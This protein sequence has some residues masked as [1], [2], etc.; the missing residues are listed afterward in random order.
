M[1]AVIVSIISRVCLCVVTGEDDTGNSKAAA[2][3]GAAAGGLG[4]DTQADSAYG[5]D[6]SDIV[7]GPFQND[8]ENQEELKKNLYLYEVGETYFFLAII[9]HH[10]Q[11]TAFLIM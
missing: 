3:S 7:L 9:R 4:T 1:F 6:D 11:Y 8:E 2:G 5:M 10:S